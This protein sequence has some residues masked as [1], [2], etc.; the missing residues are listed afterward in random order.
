MA[1]GGCSPRLPLVAW[2][3]LPKA[4][5]AW[6]C[7]L[8]LGSE[9]HGSY[10]PAQ[11]LGFVPWPRTTVIALGGCSVQAQWPSSSSLA[12]FGGAHR[13]VC[14][15]CLGFTSPPM[16]QVGNS[17]GSERCACGSWYACNC[18]VWLVSTQLKP[19]PPAVA[20]TTAGAGS[21]H[22]GPEQ[23]PSCCE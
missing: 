21:C 17:H 6:V 14:G 19:W 3:V 16:P 12:G 7:T 9:W 23:P 13:L 4:G 15:P 5:C 10:G 1:Q 11:P 18:R 20:L 22:R 8:C 2:E